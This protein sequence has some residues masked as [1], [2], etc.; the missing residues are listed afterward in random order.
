MNARSKPVESLQVSDFL[1]HSVWEYTNDDES[2][3]TAVCPVE[4]IH[5]KDLEGKIVGTRVQLANGNWVWAS[6]C[7]VDANNPRSTEQFVTI[8]LERNGRW[9]S[10]ARYHDLDYAERGPDALARFLGFTVDEVFPIQYDLTP[11]VI[12]DP[13]ALVGSVLREPRQ[14]LS[15]NELIDLA[16]HSVS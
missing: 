8:S 3:E 13:A 14:R 6:I 9:F 12:G 5:I 10:L 11:Y 16:I 15:Q 7:N 4:R 1:A 2:G